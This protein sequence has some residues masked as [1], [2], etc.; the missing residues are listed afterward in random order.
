MLTLF[1]L[2]LGINAVNLRSLL[3]P[4]S[5]LGDFL[6]RPASL[7]FALYLIVSVAYLI[8]GYRRVARLYREIERKLSE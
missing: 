7:F 6:Y 5:N 3:P 1:M 2:V 8:L 4:Q